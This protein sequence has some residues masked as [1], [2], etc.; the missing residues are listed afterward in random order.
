MLDG[1]L[2]VGI[3]VVFFAIIEAEKQLRIAFPG[4]KGR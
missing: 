4:A 3:G 1:F 2:L